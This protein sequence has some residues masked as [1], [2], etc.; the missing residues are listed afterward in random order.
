ARLRRRCFPAPERW[1]GRRFR[2][3]PPRSGEGTYLVRF[4]L[5][6]K[7]ARLRTDIDG[8]VGAAPI[9]DPQ[10]GVC[11]LIWWA[12][13]TVSYS[14]PRVGPRLVPVVRQNPM[15]GHGHT[16][17]TTALGAFD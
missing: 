5:A 15:P 2:L 10:T 16:T 6:C 8:T 7:R 1:C 13:L 11:T 14:M 17:P 4:E 12:V 9:P 3:G